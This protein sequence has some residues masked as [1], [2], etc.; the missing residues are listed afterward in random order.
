MHFLHFSSARLFD[1]TLLK[2]LNFSEDEIED[3]SYPN[4]VQSTLYTHIKH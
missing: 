4:F 3:T 1:R 2:Y